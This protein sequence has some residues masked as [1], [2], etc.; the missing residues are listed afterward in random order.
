MRHTV[1][2][3]FA[4]FGMDTITLAGDF[5]LKLEAMAN[6]GFTQVMVSARDVAGYR[7]GVRAAAHAIKASGLR[8]TGFQVLRDFEGLSGHLHD[9]KLDI[10]KR[11]IETSAALGARVMLVCSS[12]SAHAS[13]E[14]RA[15]ADDLAKLAT[16][17]TP[18]NVK[19]AFEALSWGRHINELPQAAD[20]VNLAAHPNLGLCIDSFHMF[21]TNTNLDCIDELDA[22]RIFLAQ[23]SDFMWQ[24]TRTPEERI[25]T[26]RTF[27]VFPGEGVHGA[28]LVSLV[29]KLDQIGYARDY[30]FEVFNDE[31][32][33]L[34]LDFVAERA[35]RSAQ[36]LDQ[37][38]LR[39]TPALF[40]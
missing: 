3:D 30:S 20:V 29:R 4:R 40:A 5:D 35:K 22:D 26:A 17:A 21:A 8:L 24:E 27:R 13:N 6:S 38:V 32:Q 19:I 39:S 11:M 18:F 1:L 31:Y 7:G 9:Y 28:A 2:H 25:A 33:Q 10:A 15:I 23:L 36:W 14:P 16:L 37:D 12:T 34:P